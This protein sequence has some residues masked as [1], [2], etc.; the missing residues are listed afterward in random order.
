LKKLVE[1]L[2]HGG[3][4]AAGVVMDWLTIPRQLKYLAWA[5]VGLLVLHLLVRLVTVLRK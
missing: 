1:R 3:R 2:R 4:E 5:A